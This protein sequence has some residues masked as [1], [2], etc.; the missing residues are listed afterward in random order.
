MTSRIRTG[1]KRRK[2][3]IGDLNKRIGLQ[4]RTLTEP[5]DG[6]A[7]PTLVFGTA[8]EV[9]AK[10]E[11]STGKTIFDGINT[12]VNITHTI[13]IRFRSDV[14]ETTWIAYNSIRYDIKRVENYEEVSEFLRL[15]CVIRGPTS[16]KA[17]QA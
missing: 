8:T 15:S 3:C 10:I 13:F 2:V 16:Q 4:V 11:T 7:D 12:D 17:S 6:V 5:L 1:G 14:D 9:W